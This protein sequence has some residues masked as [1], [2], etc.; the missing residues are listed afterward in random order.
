[1]SGFL[2][3]LRQAATDAGDWFDR[4]ERATDDRKCVWAGQ[5]SD[6]R[7]HKAALG[8][9]DAFPWEGAADTRVRTVDEITNEQVM[10]MFQSFVRA[11]VQATGTETSDSAWGQKV[12]TVLKYVL[13]TKMK[14]QLRRELTLAAQWR[15]W[16]GASV[17]AIMWD[18]Q[19]RKME[20]V[21]SVEGLAAV[22]LTEQEMQDPNAA[23]A[24]L[25]AAR[26][27]VLDPSREEQALKVLMGLSEILTRRTARKALEELRETGETRFDVPEVFAAEPRITALLP[28][29]DVFFPAL[30]DDIQ[31]APWVAH[32]EELSPEELRDRINTHGYDAGWVDRAIAAKGTRFDAGG[33]WSAAASLTFRVAGS[34]AE[35]NLVEIFHV[36][37]R[38]VDGTGIPQVRCS[39]VSAG[40]PDSEG[41]EEPLAYLHGEYPYVVHQREHLTRPILESRG[42]AEIAAPWQYEQKV[43]R[44]ARTDR[45]AVTVL[46]PLIVPARRGAG[47]LRLGPGAQ[48]PAAG[49]NE[50]YEWMRTPP[51]D[52]GSIEIERATERAIG[53]YFGRIAADVPS[54]LT[55]LHQGSLVDGWLLEVRQVCGQILQLCQQYMGDAQV[56]R[57]AGALGR[58]WQLTAAEIQGQF[59]LS[60]EADPRDLNIETLKEKWGFLEIIMKYDRAGRVDYGK[61]IE[62][63]MAG[64][65]PSMAESVLI[66]MEA[67]NQK[68]VSEEQDALAK[69]LAGIEPPMDPQ[70]G[71]N[72]QMRLQVL[73]ESI[74]KNP[75]M[76]RRIAAQPDTAALLDNRMKFLNFQVGQQ[77]NAMIGRV[78]AAPVMQ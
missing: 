18:Q 6:G 33:F 65:D 32:R 53:I 20:Q 30:T 57:V 70:P 1:M 52:A 63:G 14:S 3:D 56:A 24:G 40:V 8:G 60:V 66:P 9:R 2:D 43:Q 26:Q 35:Q 31:R 10:L 54:Q 16:F 62:F 11:R 12:T 25:E 69:M 22:L 39:V 48:I 46:P 37:R 44:D 4:M 51:Y 34:T 50:Q 17:T 58:P 64:I 28:M 59:D 23:Q 29:V 78:G 38:T 27:L 15:Q 45:T 77:T 42:V 5:S 71:M 21:V 75:E 74:Q 19:L 72:Y 41:R 55:G 61:L 7:K 73:Q 13:W 68:Q 49:R 36:Y 76:Q 67:A 47:R